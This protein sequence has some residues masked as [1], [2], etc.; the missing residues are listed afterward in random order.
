MTNVQ[1]CLGLA[2]LER[3]EGFIAHKKELY[4]RYVEKLDGVKG[5]RILPFRTEDVRPQPLV[6]QPLSEGRRS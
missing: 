2:Q 5:L 6:L 3:L 4:D 1:A